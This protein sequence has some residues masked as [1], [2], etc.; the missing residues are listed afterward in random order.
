MR[1]LILS[2]L[3]SL[4]CFYG[5]PAAFAAQ[6]STTQTIVFVRHGEKPEKGLG[7]LSCRGLNRSL[8][9]PAV[10]DKQFGKPDAIFAPNPSELKDDDG[11]SYAYVRPLA[12]IEPTAITFGLPVDTRFGFEDIDKLD[13]ALQEP[14]Y[15]DATVLVGWEHKQIVKLVRQ[16]IRENGGEKRAVPK[17]SGD[18]FDSMYVLRI[19]R[20]GEKTRVAFE[21]SNQGLNNLP[22]SCPTN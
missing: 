10:I 21:H 19:T 18:D 20:E 14:A 7:Q 22:E 5:A 17:W 11:T 3:I 16:I 13:K 12:T 8:R 9:L 4:S 6:E 15:R 1:R 2:A